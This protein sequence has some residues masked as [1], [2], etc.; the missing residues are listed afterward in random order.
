M[1]FQKFKLITNQM[2]TLS[3]CQNNYFQEEGK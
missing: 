2:F 1:H 3:I